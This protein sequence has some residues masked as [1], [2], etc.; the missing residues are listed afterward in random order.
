LAS[1]RVNLPFRAGA[2]PVLARVTVTTV[3]APDAV[4]LAAIDTGWAAMADSLRS[5][6]A[7]LATQ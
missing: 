6:S 5:P 2:E 7:S 4:E 1:T 3:S